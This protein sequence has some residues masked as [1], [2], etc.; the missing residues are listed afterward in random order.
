MLFD[1]FL[2]VSGPQHNCFIYAAWFLG[3]PFRGL[4]AGRGTVVI[5]F[6]KEVDEEIVAIFC[7]TTVAYGRGWTA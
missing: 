7:T 5:T 3:R 2:R 4:R 1:E 6:G